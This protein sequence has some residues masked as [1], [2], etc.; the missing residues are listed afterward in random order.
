MTDLDLDTLQTFAERLAD[1][2][3]EV[4][5][6]YFRS[7]LTIDYKSDESPV[8][9][10]DR[11][12][13]AAMR[14]LIQQHFPEHG[15]LGEEQG[16]DQADNRYTWVLDPIDGTKNFV[17][18][19]PLYGTLI[20]LLK[21]RQPI[22]G[23]VDIPPLAERWVGVQG[24]STLFYQGQTRPVQGQVSQTKKAS[25]LQEAIWY[26]TSPDFF[27][28]EE[29][30]PFERLKAELPPCRF[31]IDC[32]A[33]ALLSAGFVD[34]VIET[35]LKPYDFLALVAVVEGAGGVITDWQGQPLTQ[36]SS[37]QV[38]ASAN[39]KLHQQAL[40]LLAQPA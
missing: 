31:G 21:D 22:L 28:G 38:L 13:E 15:L 26:T 2:A 10:A 1:R 40:A 19:M 12:T 17:A 9:R 20:A 33:F 35:Q 30:A 6:S 18:G 36:D 11:E 3:R 39:A 27:V 34:L 32:Y 14:A 4:S 25:S 5:L 37:G 8:T 29:A 7:S 23:V 16:A 24:R